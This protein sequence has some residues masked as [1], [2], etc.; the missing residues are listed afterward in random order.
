MLACVLLSFLTADDVEKVGLQGTWQAKASISFDVGKPYQLT[1]QLTMTLK[2]N[3]GRFETQTTE[4]IA[5]SFC[6]PNK[7]G[8]FQWDIR[9]PQ[10]EPELKLFIPTEGR[11][12]IIESHRYQWIDDNV[13]I[14][15]FPW[16]IMMTRIAP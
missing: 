11:Q 9:S 6:C 2:G 14:V 12:P 16:P 10:G 1:W 5:N 7:N 4:I 8:S 13:L 15:A 3:K